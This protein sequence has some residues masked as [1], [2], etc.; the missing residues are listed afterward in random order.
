MTF[1]VKG[2]AALDPKSPLVP[3]TFERRDVRAD[4]V[5]IDILYCGAYATQIDIKLAMTGVLLL[6]LSYWAD[7][8]SQV[9]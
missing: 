7:V 9:Q 3:H 2:F 6:I 8:Q 5:E 4:D 1:K